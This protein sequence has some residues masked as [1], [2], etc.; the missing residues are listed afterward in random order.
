VLRNIPGPKI[1]WTMDF[2]TNSVELSGSAS[3]LSNF[4]SQ[5]LTM[6]I[7]QS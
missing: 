3:R 6:F 1:K 5:V 4:T 2:G 7:F